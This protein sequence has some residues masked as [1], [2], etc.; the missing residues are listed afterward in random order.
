MPAPAPA[1]RVRSEFDRIARLRDDP[2]DHNVRYHA[3]LLAALPA[4]CGD[5]LEIGCGTGAFTR[6][7]AERAERV[8]G[9]DLSPRM[10]EAARA[11][12]AGFA[13]VRLE[14]ADATAFEP[15]A[16]R[17][18][19]IASLA[20][21]HHLPAAETL[22]RLRD[23]LRPGGVLLVLDLVADAGPVDR[24]RSAAAFPLNAALRLV[25]TGRLRMPAEARRLWDEHARHDA[26]PTL[27]DVQALAA[28]L[29]P[30]AR[31][32]RHL[33]W[34]YSLVWRKPPVAAET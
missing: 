5:V 6:R 11:R 8:V 33:F 13:R 23:A 7:L 34:R 22:V 16:E 1:E 14:V 28:A 17:W 10:I 32:R 18:D 30:G 27:G 9:I 12:C 3:E 25:R 4:R 24:L 29:L 26:Y 31:V 2:C 15:G 19:A 20:T 21:L